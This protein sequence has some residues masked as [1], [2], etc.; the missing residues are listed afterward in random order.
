MANIII[1]GSAI[2]LKSD[3]TLDTIKKLKKYD[4]SALKIQDEKE[5]LLFKVDVAA[6]GNGSVCEK[7]IFF[8]PVTHD[9]EKKATV[10]MS[11]PDSV[12]NAAEY[13]AD[14]LGSS[15]NALEGLEDTM[16]AAAVEVDAK[17][18]AMLE[19]IVVQ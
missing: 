14:L 5:R 13:A 19:K 3:L 9:A 12:T 17:K 8:A 10:T 1:T 15:F 2:V 7:A 16:S 4:P 11:I 6:E 18:A